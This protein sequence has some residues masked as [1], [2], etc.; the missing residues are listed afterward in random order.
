METYRISSL[1]F[2]YPNRC[3][4]ALKN[5]NISVNEG[6]FVTV[7]GKSGCGKTTL[8]RLLKPAISPFGDKEGKILFCGQDIEETD[9][10]MQTEKIGFVMQNPDNQIVTDKV[11]HELCFG[12]ESLGLKTP[13]I[14]AKVAEMASFFGIENWFYKKT[15]ELSGGQKQILNL[16]SVMVMEPGVLILDEPTSQL[17]PIASREFLELV[18]KIN[19]ELGITVILAEHRLEEAIAI[20]DRVIVMDG[21]EIIADAKPDS[22]GRIL[23]EI[24]RDMFDAMPTPVRVFESVENDG[25]CP[26]TVREGKDWLSEFSKTH[27]SDETHLPKKEKS[28]NKRAVIEVKEAFYRYE[29]TAP[30][31]IKNLNLTLFE[32]EFL[33]VLGGNGTGKTT[34]I[35]LIAGI[36]KQQRGEILINGKKFSEI[37]NP[38][39]LGVLPQE[40]KSVFSKKTVFDEL[41]GMTDSKL[42][43]NERQKAVFEV[44]H[45]CRIEDTLK[46][47]PYDIS[48]GEQERVALAMVLL[49]KPQILVMDEPTKGMDAHFKKIFSQILKDLKRGGASILMVS[50]DLEFCAEYADRCALFFDGSITAE[51]DTYEFFKENRFYTTSACRMAREVLPSCV[52]AKDIIFAIGGKIDE[53]KED[54]DFNYTLDFEKELPPEKPK[55]KTAQGIFFVLSFAVLYLFRL[56]GNIGAEMPKRLLGAV[57]V[58]LL[59]CGLSCLF[60]QKELSPTDRFPQ[61][62]GLTKRTLFASVL[63]VLVIPLTIFFGVYYLGDRKYYFISLLIVLETL[64]PFFAMFE[65]RKAEA[66]EIVLIS[67]LCA[68]GVAGRIAFFMVPEFK[69]LLAVVILSGICLGGEVGFLVGAMTAFVSNFFFGQGTWT[70]WQMFALGIIGFLAG[71]LFQKGILKKTKLTISAFGFFSALVIYGGIMNPASV[72]MVTANPTKAMIYSSFLMGL[73]IDMVHA[74]ST[75]FFLWFLSEPFIEKIERIKTKYGILK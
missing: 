53:K 69:P 44:A 38:D 42:P 18:K 6:E 24:N 64:L 7:C 1:S 67:V 75:S 57:A 22:V 30:D 35:S 33:A 12:L 5:I 10:K 27:K 2:T 46:S 51:G 14:R 19:V 21:G 31:V 20:S 37:Q 28:Q 11:W 56:F 26:V 43:K 40:P 48:G 55:K 45:L 16:A 61:K 23:K 9:L 59:W 73:P 36:N 15:D 32:G 66:R 29:R 54:T 63:I 68:L 47:H 50:H 60:P 58:V 4:K 49:K 3:E 39:I 8:L 52:T 72:F 41:M 13:V 25:K 74:L 17:D 62:T 65:N 70:Q 34:A 71:V